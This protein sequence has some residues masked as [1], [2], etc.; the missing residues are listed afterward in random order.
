MTKP[1]TCIKAIP[2]HELL[3]M[4]EAI[5][6]LSSWQQSLTILEQFFSDQQVPVNKKK[7]IQDYHACALLF[8]TFHKNYVQLINKENQ[9]LVKMIGSKQAVEKE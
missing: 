1:T 3:S 6:R 4:Q 7:I 5:E 2:Y 9:L 8:Q